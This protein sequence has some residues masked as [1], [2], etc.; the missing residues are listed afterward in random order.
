MKPECVRISKIVLICL[1]I[2][3]LSF[4]F[5]QSMLTPEV[6]KAESDAVGEIVEEIIPPDTPPGEY[7]QKNLRKI[8]HFVEFALLGTEVAFFIFLFAR[9]MRYA[10]AAIVLAP[11]VALCDETIQIFSGRGPAIADVWVDT[12]GF[13]SFSL[14]VYLFC[15]AIILIRKKQIGRK[16]ENDG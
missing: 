11:I 15:F 14:L 1:I 12:A 16:Q 2:A 4:I 10:A 3:T 8:G 5:V 7:V 13:V 9:R 6:S